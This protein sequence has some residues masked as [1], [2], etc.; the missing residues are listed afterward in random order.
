MPVLDLKPLV[1][2]DDGS[3]R[4]DTS[5]LTNAIL[6]LEEASQDHNAYLRF[7]NATIPVG[8]TVDVAH[9]TLTA[10]TGAAGTAMLSKIAAVDEDNHVAP[11]TFAEWTTDNGILTT[12][13]VD[14][15]FAPL[16]SGAMQTPSLVSVLQE[17]ID[18]VGWASGN[19]IG[20]QINNDG[21]TLHRQNWQDFGDVGTAE[22]VL[23]IEYTAAAG[24][25]AASSSGSNL[26]LL[27]GVR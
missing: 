19:A 10:V 25:G 14:W 26:L 6:R 4:L 7:P 20:I 18:R 27:P 24:D 11:T 12:A 16:S 8:A 22:A 15:D 23:H 1:T 2:G 5:T 21:T 9:I 3:V 17:I 13:R